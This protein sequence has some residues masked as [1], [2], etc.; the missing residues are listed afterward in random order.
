MLKRV[1]D[2]KIGCINKKDLKNYINNK[3]AAINKYI[4]NKKLNKR[5]PNKIE[6]EDLILLLSNRDNAK[7]MLKKHKIVFISEF[8]DTI[9]KKVVDENLVLSYIN[10]YNPSDEKKASNVEDYLNLLNVTNN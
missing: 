6:I 1:L 10:D 2:K 9:N 5:S 4:V 8:E 7:A 3:N